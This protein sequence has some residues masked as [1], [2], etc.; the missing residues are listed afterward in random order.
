MIPRDCPKY[1]SCSAP[2]CPLGK[3][4]GTHLKGEPICKYLVEYVKP[5]GKARL[6]GYVAGN[7]VDTLGKVLPE[8]IASHGDIKRRLERAS[9][10]GS[11]MDAFRIPEREAA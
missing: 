10:S 1:I 5:V 9:R 8:I 11:K 6:R 3:I 2:V 7:L 4:K